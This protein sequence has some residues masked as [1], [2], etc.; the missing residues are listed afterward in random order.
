M[1]VEHLIRTENVSVRVME[2][3]E[4]GATSWHYHSEVSDYFV[5]LSGKVRVE[6]DGAD[7]IFELCPGQRTE[8]PVQRVHRVVNLYKGKSEYLLVQGVGRYDFIPACFAGEKG[9]EGDG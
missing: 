1:G 4:G 3:E 8:V 9:S 5:C 7:K 6:S 2:L